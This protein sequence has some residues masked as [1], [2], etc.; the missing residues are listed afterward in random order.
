M[1]SKL[2]NS[3]AAVK[4]A[5]I[6]G[7]GSAGAITAW[8]IN[9]LGGR[10]F[11][12]KCLSS[13]GILYLRG[14]GHS[15][16]RYFS[17]PQDWKELS[18]AHRKDL[19]ERTEDAVISAYNKTIIDECD[20][21]EFKKGHVESVAWDCGEFQIEQIYGGVR[22]VVPTDYVVAA[23]GF[24]LEESVLDLLQVSPEGRK[25]IDIQ[26]SKFNHDLSVPEEL[27]GPCIHVPAL[28]AFSQGPGFKTLGCLGLMSRR[29]VE[30]YSDPVV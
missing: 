29:I 18:E 28:A 14:D 2:R 4:I 20:R 8:L 21:I 11:E 17:D 6:G 9:A 10:P 26:G 23:L 5:V 30:A 25:S 12:I 24:D 22:S 15:E 13:K 1:A 7:G 27:F 19:L 3:T 16:R